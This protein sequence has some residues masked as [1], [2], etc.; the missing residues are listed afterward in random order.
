MERSRYYYFVTFIDDHSRYG[1]V[2]LMT[3][4]FEAFKNFKEYINEVRKQTGKVIK[5]LKKI[6][7][8][9][10]RH[11]LVYL[12]LIK[13]LRRNCTLL[14][15]IPSMVSYTNLLISMYLSWW[16]LASIKRL[17]S[18]K[19]EAKVDSGWIIS[20]FSLTIRL[21]LVGMPHFLENKKVDK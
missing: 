11:L 13:Y 15:I 9:H 4:K 3:H 17:K 16:C 1:C 2:N 5:T 18:E 12:S 14:D 6:V 19:L 7:L 21:W 20:T 8:F 10:I